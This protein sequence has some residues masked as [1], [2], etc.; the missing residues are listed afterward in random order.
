VGNPP[1]PEILDTQPKWGFYVIWAG[2]VRSTL[3]KEH[4]RIVNDPRVLSMEDS[5]YR[6]Y[7]NPYRKTCGLDLIP[8]PEKLIPGFSGTWIFNEDKS[9]L[10]NFG[11]GNL[12]YKMAIRHTDNKLEIQRTF[13]VEYADDRMTDE[14]LSLDGS[15]VKSEFWNSPRVTTAQLTPGGDSVEINSTVTFTRG[16]RTFEMVTIEIWNLIEQTN[17]L[18]IKQ[19][20]VSFRGE[21]E[22]IMI[23]ERE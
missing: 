15:E 21:R 23:Y 8:L 9:A 1:S 11:A 13:I 7:I 20:S 22:I 5:L 2:M 14:I 17:I 6:V 12:P 3:K 16:D 18:A 10:D 19:K 4:L